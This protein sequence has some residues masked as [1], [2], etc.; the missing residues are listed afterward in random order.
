LRLFC[1]FIFADDLLLFWSLSVFLGSNGNILCNVFTDLR[2]KV[3]FALCCSSRLLLYFL[4]FVN[5]G[6][7]SISVAPFNFTSRSILEVLNILG[8][9]LNLDFFLLDHFLK[10]FTL[11]GASASIASCFN[12][13][14]YHRI[15]SLSNDSADPMTSLLLFLSL[16]ILILW[17]LWVWN[18]RDSLVLCSI[19]LVAQIL[20]LFK[21]RD[22]GSSFHITLGKLIRISYPFSLGGQ[23]LYF[24]LRNFWQN[25]LRILNS[26]HGR[27]LVI[28]NLCL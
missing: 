11:V 6:L 8:L 24:Y 25:R 20:G 28:T 3:L 5:L 9:L 2:T 27:S 18:N 22:S 15:L 17:W 21:L 19:R 10:F 13:S 14:L 12:G 7:H 26:Y 4:F 1:N 23:S 16:N